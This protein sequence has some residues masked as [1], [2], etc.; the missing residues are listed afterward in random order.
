[1]TPPQ[2]EIQLVSGSTTLGV[3]HTTGKLS[4]LVSPAGNLLVEPLADEWK[5]ALSD[6]NRMQFTSLDA[7]GGDECY[8]TVGGSA[9]WNLRDH[10]NVWGKSPDLN[11]AHDNQSSSGWSWGSA[12]F[13]RTIVGKS[14]TLPAS[15]WGAFHFQVQFNNSVPLKTFN[16]ELHASFCALGVYASHAL[17]AAEPG[18]VVEWGI[19]RGHSE[20]DSLLQSDFAVEILASRKFAPDA[21]PLASKF[22]VQATPGGIFCTFFIR[23]KLG[24]RIDVLQNAHLPWVG[25]WWCH[26]G[27]GDGRPHSTVGIEPTNIPSDG[28]ILHFDTPTGTHSTSAEFAWVISNNLI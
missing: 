18:D 23:K 2:N 17:F 7:W 14:E 26:N 28:P 21:Q 20:L 5:H 11:F 12:H 8:P 6:E 27:W 1:M 13:K 3:A 4:R 10:G 25:I 9:L 24:V 22:Y 15:R 16:P 19:V